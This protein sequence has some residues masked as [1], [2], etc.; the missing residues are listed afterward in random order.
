[1]LSGALLSE[2]VIAVN[3]AI[4][5][6]LVVLWKLISEKKDPTSVLHLE[7]NSEAPSPP[8]HCPPETHRSHAFPQAGYD[9]P[10]S[11]LFSDAAQQCLRFY[12]VST[13]TQKVDPSVQKSTSYPPS[14]YFTFI[15][16]H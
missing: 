14:L 10:S 5:C 11:S 4:M 8:P 2:K 9:R 13:G 15:M 3:I 16:N 1:M 7:Y 6:A 12:K